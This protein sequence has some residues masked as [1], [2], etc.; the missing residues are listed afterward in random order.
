MKNKTLRLKEQEKEVTF[1][2]LQKNERSM[3]SSDRVE[4]LIREVEGCRWDA[5]LTSESGRSEKAEIWETRQGHKHMGAGSFENKHGV[6]ILSKL[7]VGREINWTDYIN[8]RGQYHSQQAVCVVD[9]CVL[10]PLWIC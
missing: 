5:L 6:G 3:N 10:S 2:V 9:E 7:E 4:K 8:K 1:I